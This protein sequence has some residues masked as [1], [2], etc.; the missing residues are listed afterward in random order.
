[1]HQDETPNDDGE[2]HEA[3]ASPKAAFAPLTTSTPIFGPPLNTTL[4]ET[5]APHEERTLINPNLL[6]RTDIPPPKF[7]FHFNKYAHRLNEP[8]ASAPNPMSSAAQ[9]LYANQYPPRVHGWDRTRVTEN[10]DKIQTNLWQQVPPPKIFAY[11]WNGTHQE[12]AAPAVEQIQEAIADIMKIPQPTVTAPAAAVMNNQFPAPPLCYLI[13]QITEA[14]ADTLLRKQFWTTPTLSFFVIPFA[15]SPS[16]FA[17]ALDNLTYT[18]T[19]HQE[20]QRMAKEAI[21][22]NPQARAHVE[23]LTT[24]ENAFLSI[25]HSL[26][27]A[28][29][30][31]L[32][33][34]GERKKI[35]WNLYIDPPSEDPDLHSEWIKIISE[36]SFAT[37]LYGIAKTRSH[38]RCVGCKSIDHPTGL[39]PFPKLGGSFAKPFQATQPPQQQDTV[40]G[41]GRGSR[42]GQRGRGRSWGNRFNTLSY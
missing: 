42:R 9:S 33:K 31:M 26:E 38:P 13:T 8:Q 35:V 32:V 18:E 34:G 24:T 14:M 28:A 2:A 11:L 30:P 15:P 41:R 25:V 37:T 22:E 5:R 17:C 29:L 39:C 4:N 12:D 3:T 21:W 6:E 10:V 20:V 27:A 7:T 36:T 23:S 19:H 16:R 1:M 40:R